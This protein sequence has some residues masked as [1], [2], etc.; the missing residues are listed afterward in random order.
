MTREPSLTPTDV[1]LLRELERTPN[2]VRAARAIGIRRDRAVYRLRRLGSLFGPVAA[3][4]R[5]GV[6]GG[7]TRLTPLGRRL[8]ARTRGDRPGSNRWT[9]A[10]RRGPP[11]SVDLGPGRRLEVTFPAREGAR[12]T[13]EVDPDALIVALRPAELSARNG[14]RATVE[15]VRLRADGTAL[16]TARWAGAPVRAEVTVGSVRRLRLA[17]GRTVVLYAK[18]VS[19][20]RRVSPG[21]PRS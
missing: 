2:V 14:L 9:G 15:R 1:R 18:A 5:G 12:V 10:Y 6:Q 21:P 20:R 3:A 8:L 16:V 4:V 19:V 17:P 13:V 7:S 11:P